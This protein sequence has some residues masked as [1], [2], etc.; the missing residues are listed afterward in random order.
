MKTMNKKP[1]IIRNVE[2]LEL[3]ERKVRRRIK[4]AELELG[5]RMKQM[6]EEIVTSALMKLVSGIIEGKT[7]KSL[8]GIAKKVGK[9]ALFKLFND[10]EE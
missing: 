4:E 6:P 10:D 9:S 1:V 5:L 2:E 7:I 3:H 8:A